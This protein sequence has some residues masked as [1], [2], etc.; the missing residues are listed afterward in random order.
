M[1]YPFKVYQTQVDGHVF[2]V[3]ESPCLKGCVGQGDSIEV[4]LNELAENEE[5]WLE[6]AEKY[7]ITIP[8]I[9]VEQIIEYS[10]KFTVRVSPYVHKVAVEMAKK[11]NISLNQY[12]NDAIVAQ[13]ARL[14][15]IEYI[16]PKV[17]EAVDTLKRFIF[18][19]PQTHSRGNQ[20]IR[21]ALSAQKWFS[22]AATTSTE[23]E[24]YM[25]PLGM[26]N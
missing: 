9:P 12:V 22:D 3:A 24:P 6:T 25:I 23:N 1:K 19:S 15:T 8:D 16:V 11:E 21:S 2:W 18:E 26:H 13:N 7:G 17:K 4:A 14:E 5:V 20:S 10:G